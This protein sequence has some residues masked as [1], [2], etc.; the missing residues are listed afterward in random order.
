MEYISPEDFA[1]LLCEG[2]SRCLKEREEKEKEKTKNE[3]QF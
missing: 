2:I 3:E 1:D